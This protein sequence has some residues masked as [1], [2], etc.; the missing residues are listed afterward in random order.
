MDAHWIDLDGAANTRDLGGLPAK[1]G[2]VRPNR[3]IRS[4]NLQ[5]LTPADVRLLVD[6]HGVRTIADLRTHTEVDLEG[7]GPLTREPRVTVVHL[8]LFPEVGARTDVVAVEEAGPPVLPWQNRDG[9]RKDRGGAAEVYL[10]YL[11][12]R[13]DSIVSALRLI[14]QH[15]GATV[16]HCAAGKDRTGVVVALA[17]DEIGVDR[18]AIVE[19]YVRTGERLTQLLA[20]L[21]ASPTYADDVQRVPDEQHK[22]RPETMQN[23]L[24]SLDELHGGSSAWLRGHG[25]TD[26]DAAALHTALLAD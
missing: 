6:D 3:L 4:A 17:L 2:T 9:S 5:A 1:Q 21:K 12:D 10:R 19:D 13:P 7:P 8:S 15:N 22:P 23:F 14:A 16:V 26:S 24:A 11:L 18:E 25:W 20:R